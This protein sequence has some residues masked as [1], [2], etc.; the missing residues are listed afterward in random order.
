MAD[1]LLK[2]LIAG[3]Q[4]YVGE[5]VKYY[6]VSK[7]FQ[8]LS[9]L[10][11]ELDYRDLSMIRKFL[12]AQK[13][14]CVIMTVARPFNSTLPTE[15]AKQWALNNHL[16]EDNLIT[17][18]T[19]YEIPRL[20]HL[21]SQSIFGEKAPTE[22]ISLSDI[23]RPTSQYAAA[24]FKSTYKIE[25]LSLGTRQKWINLVIPGVCGFYRKTSN[26]YSYF[27]PGIIQK[28]V[29]REKINL[30][31]RI[32]TQNREYVSTLDI[33]QIIEML[34]KT[35]NFDVFIN[36]RLNIC[37][38]YSYTVKNI[39]D[40]VG[41]FVTHHDDDKL[42]LSKILTPY[43]SKMKSEI[44]LELFGY[45]PTTLYDM[46]SWQVNRVRVTDHFKY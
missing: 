6:L 42:N 23:I 20:I 2:I 22:Q 26:S 37:A 46:I 24:K 16:A 30:S 44:N 18:A 32:L 31:P 36:R 13:I 4:G 45:S 15:Q 41:T 43:S 28:T 35:D 34:L 9:P 40:F 39:L 8:V 5:T 12:V 38:E 25:K 19:E 17:A 33:S 10:R 21:S 14:S 7:G 1:S 27:L 11:S 3:G 29:N